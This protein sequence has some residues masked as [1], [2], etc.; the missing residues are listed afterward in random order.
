MRTI[1]DHQRGRVYAWEQRV[2]APHDPTRIAREQAQAM[3]DAIW[4]DIGL[5]YP[6]KVAALPVQAKTLIG[7]ADRLTIELAPRVPS[8]CLL[9]EL[10]HSITSSVEGDSD[11][12]GALFLAAYFFLL[13]RYLRR[14]PGELRQSAAQAG[15]NVGSE[16]SVADQAFRP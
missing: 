6:P 16:F 7:R 3:I 13:Q 5:R 10:A 4:A 2:I 11:G 8:W 14:D 15:L 1:R 9:H 12:H